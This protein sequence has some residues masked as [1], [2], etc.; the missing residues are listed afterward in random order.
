MTTAYEMC[1]FY[2][3]LLDEGELDGVRVFE[4]STVRHA[5]TEQSFWEIDFTLI[6]PLRYGLGFMLGNEK[7]GPFGTDNPS[8][9]GHIGPLEHL[10]LG[11]SGARPLGGAHQHRKADH[12]PPRGAPRPVPCSR[13]GRA[14]PKVAR[15]RGETSPRIERAD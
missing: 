3:C 12:Q 8:A 14:F 2:Q 6:L 7:I 5:I 9:F 15:R 11:R 10:C 4:P 1:A 13:S